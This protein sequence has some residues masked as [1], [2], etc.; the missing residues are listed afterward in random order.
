MSVNKFEAGGRGNKP[1]NKAMGLVLKRLRQ[2]AGLSMRDLAD[3]LGTPHSLVGK[4]EN[5]DREMT[6]TEF[7][8]YL[9]ALEADPAKVFKQVMEIYEEEGQFTK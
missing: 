2:D 9:K 7:I 5:N 3:K 6:V 8:T 1:V 4:L